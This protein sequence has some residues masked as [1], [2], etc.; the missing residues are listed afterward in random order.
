MSYRGLAYST[1]VSP[2]TANRIVDTA[3]GV[4]NN[5][6]P[7]VYIFSDHSRGTESGNSPGFGLSLVAESTTGVLLSAEAAAEVGS[8]NLP[9]DVGKDAS[10]A[11]C[12]EIRRGGCIDTSN[13]A[14][15]LLFMALAPEDV[16]KVRF[17]KLNPY[18]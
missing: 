5:I 2:Q 11:L 4:F 9:E 10:N 17:G 6:I 18:R 8:G 7:D 15:V 13:Q 12:E 14:L 1:R 3:R 16:S